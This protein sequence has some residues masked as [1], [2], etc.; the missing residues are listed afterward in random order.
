MEL[1]PH[2]FVIN[3]KKK[4]KEK[5]KQLKNTTQKFHIVK[6]LNGKLHTNK[7]REH[8]SITHT[9]NYIK[10]TKMRFTI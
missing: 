9:S 4:E 7:E 10:Y 6:P 3:K 5:T 8:M 2:H 1:Q